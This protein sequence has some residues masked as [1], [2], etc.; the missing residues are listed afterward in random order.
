MCVCVCVCAQRTGQSD[1]FKTV[2]ATDFKFDAHV[3]RDSPDVTLIN[4]SKRGVCKNSLGGDMHFRE[5]LLVDLSI[6]LSMFRTEETLMVCR[7]GF[8]S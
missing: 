6:I 8:Y 7:T 3:S 2:K 4:F 1:E 5:R